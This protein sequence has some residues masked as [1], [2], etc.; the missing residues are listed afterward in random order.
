MDKNNS[1]RLVLSKETLRSLT[2]GLMRRV[3]GG[4]GPALP[5]DP[6]MSENCD[7]GDG[8]AGDGGTTGG[9]GT[10][11]ASGGAGG[12]SVDGGSK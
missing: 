3:I 8:G 12:G 2:Q 7:T 1:K 6:W 10:T 4:H 5:N 9:T 11:G